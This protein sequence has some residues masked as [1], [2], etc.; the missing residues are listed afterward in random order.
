MDNTKV[1]R[2]TSGAITLGNF[3]GRLK[4]T[5]GVDEHPSPKEQNLG[6]QFSI[7]THMR[8][9]WGIPK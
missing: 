3:T 4:R 7:K 5:P 1:L 9:V 6:Q 2:S 8:T